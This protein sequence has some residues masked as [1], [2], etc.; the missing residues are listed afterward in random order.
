MRTHKFHFKRSTWELENMRLKNPLS[1]TI[2]ETIMIKVIWKEVAK[3]NINWRQI[4]KKKRGGVGRD[5]KREKKKQASRRNLFSSFSFKML[6]TKS[7]VCMPRTNSEKWVTLGSR[8]WSRFH[9]CRCWLGHGQSQQH[10][11]LGRSPGQA[12]RTDP[13]LDQQ[14]QGLFGD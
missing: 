9:S 1:R 7:T 12:L 11:S 13:N 3:M 5:R 14:E 2:Y 8:R 6:I 10:R 4:K